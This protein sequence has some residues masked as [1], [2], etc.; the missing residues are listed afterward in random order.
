MKSFLQAKLLATPPARRL[1][2]QRQRRRVHRRFSLSMRMARAISAH[3]A[4]FPANFC[5]SAPLHTNCACLHH[6]LTSW[7]GAL[8]SLSLSMRCRVY[9]HNLATHS[10]CFWRPASA[11]PMFAPC[12]SCSGFLIIRERSHSTRCCERC[13]TASSSRAACRGSL[14]SSASE[15]EDEDDDDWMSEASSSD[16]SMPAPPP[17]KPSARKPPAAPVASQQE[18]EDFLLAKALSD[19][20]DDE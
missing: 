11:R 4:R 3:G 10:S 1:H 20:E 18:H 2:Q 17:R 7:P 9:A 19:C 5:S 8:S 14:S 16:R 12:A 15:A 6:Q 13:T